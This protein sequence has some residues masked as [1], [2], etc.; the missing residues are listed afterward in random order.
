[1]ATLLRKAF[2]TEGFSEKLKSFR[3]LDEVWK[4]LMLE[5]K[6]YSFNA[7]FHP[8]TRKIMEK[9]EFEHEKAYDGKYPEG[10]PTSVRI[11]LSDKQELDSQLVMFPTGHSQNQTANLS[12]ILEH[13]FRLLGSLA[14]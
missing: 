8:M 12:D 4:T 5:P 9:V 6:D 13:K 1:V 7:L 2:E 11:T 3:T 14:L 10:I